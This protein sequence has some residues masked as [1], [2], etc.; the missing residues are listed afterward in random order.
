[1]AKQAM[2]QAEIENTSLRVQYW[3]NR[4]KH[5]EDVLQPC[6]SVEEAVKAVDRGRKPDDAMTPL[7]I[8]CLRHAVEVCPISCNL[9]NNFKTRWTM[10]QNQKIN[11][12]VKQLGKMMHYTPFTIEYKAKKKPKGIRIILEIT[13]EEMDVLMQG[14]K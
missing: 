13:Q 14:K 8:M 10:T 2:K 5:S 9:T 6:K 3:L 12:L 11:A 1:M 7:D 4:I